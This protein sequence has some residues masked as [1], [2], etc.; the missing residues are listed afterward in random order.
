MNRATSA[1]SRRKRAA[2]KKSFVMFFKLSEA[3]FSSR[4]SNAE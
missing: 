4:L 2:Y 1:G 3:T